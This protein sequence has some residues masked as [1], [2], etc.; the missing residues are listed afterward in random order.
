MDFLRQEKGGQEYFKENRT[1]TIYPTERLASRIYEHEVQIDDLATNKFR[2]TIVLK[3]PK[4]GPFDKGG[5][6]EYEDSPA[7][8]R[9][10]DEMKRINRFLDSADIE[11]DDF[12][13]DEEQAVDS[14]DRRLRRVFTNGSFESGGRLFGG[15]WQHLKKTERAEGLRIKGEHIITLDYSQMA[16]R[17][18][19]GEVGCQPP[20][21]DGYV[22]PDLEKYREATKT[23][24]NSALCSDKRPLRA[25]KGTRENL[26]RKIHFMFVLQ[27]LEEHHAPIVPLFYKSEGH[28][29]Q[30]IESQI[31]VALL[32]WLQ[33][34]GI[35]ALPI[36]DAVIIAESD[37]DTTKK[38]MEQ[39]FKEMTRID[40]IVR[41]E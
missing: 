18:A 9:Y 1:T 23:I 11:F 27:H 12:V 31:L 13:V 40:G 3:R 16:L 2:E 22:L 21:G 5:R 14:Q 35:V 36:H 7:T 39:V 41:A 32:L 6:I 10:R 24:F 17:I 26:P 38:T 33:D 28:R 29:I 20:P 8:R 34:Q 15:F 30:F 4:T 25:P 37:A 19:Y